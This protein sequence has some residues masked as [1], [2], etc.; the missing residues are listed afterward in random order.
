[1]NGQA[2]QILSVSLRPTLIFK[3]S[4][5][6]AMVEISRSELVG[7]LLGLFADD[8]LNPEVGSITISK[9]HLTNFLKM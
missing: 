2:K 8:L 7:R 3:L 6:A 5:L 4:R 9:K 1:M